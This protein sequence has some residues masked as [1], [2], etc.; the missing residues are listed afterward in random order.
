[1]AKE[2]LRQQHENAT[3]AAA[4]EA[5]QEV[6]EAKYDRPIQQARGSEIEISAAAE[7]VTPKLRPV[8]GPQTSVDD[9]GQRPDRATIVDPATF[10][11]RQVAQEF[12]ANEVLEESS[13]SSDTI[14]EPTGRKLIEDSNPIGQLS[15]P[16]TL[17][18]EDV[19]SLTGDTGVETSDASGPSSLSEGHHNIPVMLVGSSRAASEE[20][21]ILSRLAASNSKPTIVSLPLA[22]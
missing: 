1:V 17:L 9:K 13:G 11:A 2:S 8:S 16:L 21:I 7:V 4:I 10:A 12:V 6:Q 15:G 19:P 18:D 5:T 14:Q 3:N 20:E 22:V